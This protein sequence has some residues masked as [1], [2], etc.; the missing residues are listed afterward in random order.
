MKQYQVRSANF[1][2]DAEILRQLFREYADWLAV[3][4]NFQDF[5]TELAGL[6]GKYAR[7]Q[8]AAFLAT[9]P[10]GVIGCIAMRPLDHIDPGTCEM[11][12]LFLR[13]QARGTGMGRK[14]AET[15]IETA[16]WAGYRR[17][18]L[19]TLDHMTDALRLYGRLG[20]NQTEA[21]Y[22]NPILG[23]VYLSLDL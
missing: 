2:N 4:L 16:R 17:M 22:S 1:P 10:D 21:Y 6:P 8:G 18:V 19:D 5:D 12:R 3:D 20:F 9:G 23:A 14:L 13:S 7:P 11:K 15:L